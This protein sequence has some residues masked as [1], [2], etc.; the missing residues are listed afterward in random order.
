MVD[1]A[2]TLLEAAGI[3]RYEGIQGR[4]LW[5]MLTGTTG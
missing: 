1:I 4:S 5:K 2:P 3:E